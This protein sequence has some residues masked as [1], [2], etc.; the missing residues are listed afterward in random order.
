M[1]IPSEADSIPASRFELGVNTYFAISRLFD[2]SVRAPME[3]LIR[4]RMKRQNQMLRLRAFGDLQRLK[5]VE[6]TYSDESQDFL[7]GL[8]L[9]YEWIKPINERW[10]GYYGLDLE[11][12]QKRSF[13]TNTRDG[14]DP[15]ADPITFREKTNVYQHTDRIALSPL[16]GIR[17]SL[18]KKLLL[19]TEFRLANYMEW[20]KTGEEYSTKPMEGNGDYQIQTRSEETVKEKGIRFRPYTGI[21]LNYR[22]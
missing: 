9:G 8:A 10:E 7:Y 12:S 15:E 17:F 1:L 2:Q 3:L 11:G 13:D 20:T 19:S 18:S 6:F 22:F 4:K 14:Y 16:L 21:F 5:Y